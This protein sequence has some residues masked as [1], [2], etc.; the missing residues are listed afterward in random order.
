MVSV[1]EDLTRPITEQYTQVFVG[2]AVHDVDVALDGNMFAGF[3]FSDVTFKYK[4]GSFWFPNNN[5]LQGCEIEVEQGKVLPANTPLSSMCRIIPKAVVET[6]AST[7]G[8]PVRPTHVGCVIPTKNGSVRTKTT[9]RYKGQDC[10][11]SHS[12]T[13]MGIPIPATRAS[14][15]Q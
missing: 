8:A 1:Y 10:R 9:G 14:R 13:R 5:R 4:G 11:R 15:T 12:Q 2:G 7:V 6:D 3:S